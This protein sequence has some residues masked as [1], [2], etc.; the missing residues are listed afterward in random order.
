MASRDL[1]ATHSPAVT[2]T[3]AASAILVDHIVL[4]PARQVAA[5]C[6]I[7]SQRLARAKETGHVDRGI[8]YGK[9]LLRTNR[10]GTTS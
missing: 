5:L 3:F 7:S 9:T 4:M 10:I 8:A 1:S 6:A 2:L